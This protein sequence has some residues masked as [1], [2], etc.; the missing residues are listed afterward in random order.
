MAHKIVSCPRWDSNPQ[1]VSL[2]Q[3]SY[4]YATEAAQ[5]LW[6]EL[7]THAHVY[8]CVHVHMYMCVHIYM[9]MYMHVHVFY[10]LST[11]FL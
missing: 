2:H 9:Y 10:V 6:I 5:W 7:H 1:Y 4:H 8:M 11:S 3:C